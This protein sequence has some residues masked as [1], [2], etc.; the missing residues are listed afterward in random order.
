MDGDLMDWVDER[1]RRAAPRALGAEA[2]TAEQAE[3]VAR[4]VVAAKGRELSGVSRVRRFIGGTA[5]GIGIL[6]LGV[7]AAAAAPAVIDWLGWAPDVVAQRSFE[8]GDG[9]ELGLCE[10]F[11]RVTPVYSDDMSDGEVDRRTQEAREFI[12]EHD[13]EP[14]IFSITGNEIE[15]AFAAEIAQRSVPTSDGTMPPPASLSLVVTQLMGERIS[16]EF[17]LAGYLR[18]GVSLESAAGPCTGAT[19]TPTQ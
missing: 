15:E 19:E 13:W 2:A 3:A 11:I 9:S 1:V 14:L 8:V 5:L 17:Q 4:A 12:T 16:D 7:T 18:H 10:V 6:G